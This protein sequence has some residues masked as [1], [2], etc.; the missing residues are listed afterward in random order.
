MS[1]WIKKFERDSKLKS[2]IVLSGNTADIIKGKNGKYVNTTNFIIDILNDNFSNVILWDRISGINKLSKSSGGFYDIIQDNLGDDEESYDIGEDDKSNHNDTG[3]YKDINDFFGF[4]LQKINSKTCFILDYS[5]YIFSSNSSM[6]DQEKQ[7]LT[8]L[9]KSINENANYD[10]LNTDMIKQGCLVVILT[11]KLAT[12]PS[13]FYV[14]DAN[15]STI[16]IPIPSRANRS[17]FVEYTESMIEFEPALDGLRLNDFIDTLDG[18]TLKDIAQIIKL[19]RISEPK[20][21][22]E[23]TI[24][25]YKYGESKSPWEDLSRDKIANIQNI[26]KER[27]KGQDE[28]IEKVENVII[29]AFTG[30]SGLQ[31]STKVKKPKGVLFFVGPTGVGKTELA[32]SLANFLFGDETACIRFD[33]SEFNH[34]HSDQRLVGAPPGYVGYEEG[35]QLTN[36]I[37]AKPFSVLLF[38]EIEKAHGKILDKFLQILEDGRLTDGK[39][40]TVSFAESVIIFTSNIGASDTANSDNVKEVK[41]QFLEKVKDHFIV[42]LKRPELLNRI[43]SDNIVPFNF[44]NS[45]DFLV[46]IAKSKFEKI[47]QFVKEKYKISTIK[48][49]DEEKSYKILASRVDK[50]NGGRG[51]LNM[52]ESSIINPLSAFVFENFDRLIGRTLTIKIENEKFGTFEFEL[53]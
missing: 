45:D 40:E 30:F 9:K 41:R 39:G 32:K 21:S 15:V 47:K 36:A 7:W 17:E 1:E 18:F 19:S 11:Q 6:G 42:T 5:D 51:V 44:I 37:K 13:S 49:D 10:L 3:K 24:N 38:D 16:T 48:F 31:H 25:L 35:G 50:N 22:Y 8:I 46:E 28:A 53:K 23:K 33:M 4:M 29:R 52:L 12:V 14:G 20:L 2:A 43:G 27:V 26:L 34:E